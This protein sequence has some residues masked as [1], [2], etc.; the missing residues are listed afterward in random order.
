VKINGGIA[1][2]L[3]GDGGYEQ[4]KLGLKHYQKE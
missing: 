1:H 3:L 4:E 2:Q